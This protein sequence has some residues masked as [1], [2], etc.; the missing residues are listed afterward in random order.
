LGHLSS[1]SIGLVGSLIATSGPG[2]LLLQPG[3]LSFGGIPSLRGH[4][5]GS[6]DHAAVNMTPTKIERKTRRTS[7]DRKLLIISSPG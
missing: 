7:N 5:F 4:M 1:I 3:Q 6:N 2:A